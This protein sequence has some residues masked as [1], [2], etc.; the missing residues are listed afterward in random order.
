MARIGARSDRMLLSVDPK[1]GTVVRVALLAAPSWLD[2]AV[3]SGTRTAEEQRELWRL[4]RNAD[5]ETVETE[6]VVTQKDGYI[7]RSRHQADE[8]G[9]P[10]EAIDIVAYENGNITWNEAENA[11]RSA[12]VIGFATASGIKLSGG[13]KWDWDLGH[14]ELA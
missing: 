10:G 8:D 1:L 12:Y 7:M 6:N 3:I 14:L 5:G 13:V 11:A 4:G 2:F 9:A